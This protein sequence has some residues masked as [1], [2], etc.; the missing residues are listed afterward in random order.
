MRAAG[1]P[2][3]ARG[4]VMSAQTDAAA[5]EHGFLAMIARR[6]ADNLEPLP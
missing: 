2:G 6:T 5:E 1:A 3:V 4:V